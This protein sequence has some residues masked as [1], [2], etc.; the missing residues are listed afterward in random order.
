M[1]NPTQLFRRNSAWRKHVLRSLA[2][3]IIVHGRITT[4][5]ARAKELRKHVDRL[6]TRAKTNTL[7]S[8][9]LAA[10]FLRNVETK[11]NKSALSHLFDVLGPKYKERNGGYTRI[12]KLPNRSGDNA[13]IAIIEL[14]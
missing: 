9:R 2:T 14:V 11:N 12:L 3:D 7:A 8:R 1:A 4:T 13:P 5:L 10:A 6:I